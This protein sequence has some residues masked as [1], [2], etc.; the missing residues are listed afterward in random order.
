[1]VILPPS[2]GVHWTSVAKDITSG[3]SSG[4]AKASPAEASAPP[5]R[6]G[7]SDVIEALWSGNALVSIFTLGL[8][9]VA[10]VVWLVLRKRYLL[11]GLLVAVVV[12]VLLLSRVQRRSPRVRFR[13]RHRDALEPA[14]EPA[15]RG[16]SE[17][18]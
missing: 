14:V 5:P 17:R 2:G 3:G 9:S 18:G 15:T 12:V 11:A 13:R 1:M 6:V 8:G 4:A 7:P 10:F 16:R